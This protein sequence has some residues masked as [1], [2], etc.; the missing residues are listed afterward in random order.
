MRILHIVGG[1]NRGGAETW[2]VQVLRRIDREKYQFDF[3]VHGQGP[4]HYQAEVQALGSRVITCIPPTNP[5]AYSMNLVHILREYGPYDCVHSHVHYFSG[6]P[7]LLARW[8]GVPTRLVQSHLDTVQ[9]EAESGVVR[10]IY[11][12]IMKHLIWATATKG[13]AVSRRAAGSLFPPD[14]NERRRWN[15]MTLGIDLEPFRKSADRREVRDELGIPGDAF[16]VGHVGRL[17]DQKN[18]AFLLDIAAAF[19][20]IASNAIF[21]LLGDGPLRAQIE[22]KARI[23]GLGGSIIFGGVRSDVPRVMKGA[24]DAFIFPSR[25]EGLGLAVIEAQA[26][27]LPCLISDVVPQEANA[28]IGLAFS[29]SLMEPPDAWARRLLRFCDLKNRADLDFSTLA[30]FKS[31]ESSCEQ[32]LD[33]YRTPGA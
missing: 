11:I 18:H 6:L 15:V 31:I 28:G 4:Y 5:L 23:L 10:R 33:L 13:T 12:W 16:V 22:Q 2:L 32:L 26:A 19:M 29:C 20:K 9:H 17:E 7:L 25:Y 14:W 27:G 30:R 1:L 8:A 3:L 21:L 24:M